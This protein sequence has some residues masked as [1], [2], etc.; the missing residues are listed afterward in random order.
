MSSTEDSGNKCSSGPISSFTIQSI[1]GN[2]KTTTSESPRTA[3]TKDVSKGLL[4][5]PAR[6]RSLSVSSE[7]DECSAGEDCFCSDTG[8]SEPCSQHQHQP[9][10]NFSCLGKHHCF[11]KGILS[12]SFACV[13]WGCFGVLPIDVTLKKQQMKTIHLTVG[14]RRYCLY[15]LIWFI[16][17]LHNINCVILKWLRR[18]ATK[19]QMDN[20]YNNDTVH[21]RQSSFKFFV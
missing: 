18:C 2:N 10:R 9:P 8:H 11:L 17:Q 13:Q 14:E 5:P 4:P 21:I 12:S 6:R 19:I 3:G 20:K 16:R 7:E 15:D 1:L